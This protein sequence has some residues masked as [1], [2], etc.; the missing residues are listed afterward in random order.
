M[1]EYLWKNAQ[2]T[3]SIDLEPTTKP[4]INASDILP[5]NYPTRR[6]IGSKVTDIKNLTAEEVVNKISQGK[7]FKVKD[8][9]KDVNRLYGT[10]GSVII[11]PP[12]CLN[13]PDLMLEFMHVAKQSSLGTADT[14]TVYQW[15]KTDIGVGYAPV[16]WII[17]NK[18]VV[19]FAKKMLGN[20]PLADNVILVTEEEINIHIHGNRLFAGWTVPIKLQTAKTVLPP[21]CLILESY[22]NLHSVGYTL[23]SGR[24]NAVR[25]VV[26][27]NFYEAFVTFMHPQSK[28]SGPGTD[29]FF[30]R[31]YISTMYPEPAQPPQTTV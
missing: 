28:Y 10:G 22:G 4:T 5:E 12:I 27:K 25:T 15:F 31:D 2:P 13:L 17:S 16:A 20:N 23:L 9:T 11:N 3:T 6:I 1:L 29:G 30:C 8:V 7:R 18:T 26:E 24:F 14:I 21:A 19:S